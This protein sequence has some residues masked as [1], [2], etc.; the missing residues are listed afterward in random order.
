MERIES[1]MQRGLQRRGMREVG[2]ATKGNLERAVQILHTADSVAIVTG[3]PILGTGKGETDGITG[4]LALAETLAEKG[5]T[6]VLV[7]DSVNCPL[8][9]AGVKKS[10]K[11]PILSREEFAS[12]I[13]RGSRRV[14]M[15]VER[16]GKA[17]DGSYYSMRGECLDEEVED[18]DTLFLWAKKEGI[19]TMAIGDG[20]NELGLGAYREF[21]ERQVVMGARIAAKEAADLVMVAG[22]SNWGAHGVCAGL[23]GI[24]D[25]KTEMEREEARLKKIVRAGAVDGT[26]RRREA[27]VDGYS[28]IEYLARVREIYNK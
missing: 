20:G 26:T 3:F 14:L 18:F 15:S 12:C 27:T 7:S 6:V 4:S 2:E 9:V 13:W 5:M 25:P 19:V 24:S 16:P 8:L 23:K 11:I 22:T 21:I 1:V 28:I 17:S 10:L